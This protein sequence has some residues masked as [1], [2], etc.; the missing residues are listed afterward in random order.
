MGDICFSYLKQFSVVIFECTCIF[1]IR[2][3]SPAFRESEGTLNLVRLSVRQSVS[4]SKTLTWVI[5]FE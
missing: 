2:L 1:I 5:T 3:L 4:P